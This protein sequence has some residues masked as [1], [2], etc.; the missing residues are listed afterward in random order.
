MARRPEEGISNTDLLEGPP[1]MSCQGEEGIAI[2]TGPPR[3]KGP[4]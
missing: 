4:I 3:A 2:E 1:R